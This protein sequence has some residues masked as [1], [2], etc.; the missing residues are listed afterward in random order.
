M[1]LFKTSTVFI[2]GM[3]LGSFIYACTQ[4]VRA[5]ISQDIEWCSVVSEIAI[6]VQDDRQRLNLTVFEFM[7]KLNAEIE[8]EDQFSQLIKMVA[9]TVFNNH[10]HDVAPYAV[11]E[12]EFNRCMRARTLGTYSETF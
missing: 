6:V 7:R 1:R 12:D 2:L 5:D 10:R 9:I 11:G 3:T 8:K 4:K